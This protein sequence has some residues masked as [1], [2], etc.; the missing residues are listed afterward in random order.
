MSVKPG[1]F[2]IAYTDGVIEATN[3]AAEEWGVQG[4]LRA[5]AAWTPKSSADAKDLVRLIFG[6]LDDF[7]Q[8]RQTDDRTVSV[9]RVA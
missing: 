8:G 6:S 2:L 4:L 9:L 1:D 7:S 3:P 5:A